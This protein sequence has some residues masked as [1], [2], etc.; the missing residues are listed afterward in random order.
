VQM[1]RLRQDI[2]TNR[3]Y[4]QQT[5]KQKRR[6]YPYHLDRSACTVCPVTV[7]QADA[8]ARKYK[9]LKK[10][11]VYFHSSGPRVFKT[12]SLLLYPLK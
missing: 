7:A 4:V 8:I 2:R 3:T 6:K 1:D 10:Y 5:N 9:Y 11:F 12:I